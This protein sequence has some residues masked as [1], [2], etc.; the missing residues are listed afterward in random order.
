MTVYDEA[1]AAGDWHLSNSN[2]ENQGEPYSLELPDPKPNGPNVKRDKLRFFNDAQEFTL[3]SPEMHDEFLLQYQLPIMEK[4]GL[5][6]Y[7]CCEDV[8]T[9]ID[10]LRKIHNL[11]RIAVTPR[12]DVARCAQQIQRDYILS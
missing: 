11:R 8:T 9:K 3:V 5:V 1:E 6:A 2:V 4:F 7:G 12:A 10:I